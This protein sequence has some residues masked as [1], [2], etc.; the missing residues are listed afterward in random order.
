M[1]FWQEAKGLAKSLWFD[2]FWYLMLFLITFG[3]V[4]SHGEFPWWTWLWIPGSILVMFFIIL[5][6]QRYGYRW[7]KEEEDAKDPMRYSVKKVKFSMEKGGNSVNT[8]IIVRYARK[9]DAH[10]LY[11]LY[12]GDWSNFIMLGHS[13]YEYEEMILASHVKVIG[14]FREDAFLE[15][16]TSTAVGI[17]IAVDVVCWG[18]L[19]IIYVDEEYRKLGVGKRMIDLLIASNPKWKKLEAGD[20]NE[21]EKIKEM[22]FQYVE[23]LN[24][25][26]KS[27]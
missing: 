14:A 9:E 11:Q 27:L 22:G 23:P 21:N 25:C 6:K 4:L 5:C 2:P 17:L 3:P 1:T 10:T 8:E 20:I 13:F 18:Y 16:K 7:N 15:I 12:N 19:D 26:V 24:W